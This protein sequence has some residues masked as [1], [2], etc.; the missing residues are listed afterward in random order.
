[1]VW[2]AAA[3]HPLCPPAAL[4]RVASGSEHQRAAAAANIACPQH[5]LRVL[6]ADRA[7]HVTAAAAGRCTAGPLLERAASD[8]AASDV[9]PGAMPVTVAALAGNP[10][11]A[12]RLLARLAAADIDE[13]AKER[14]AGNLRCPP[15][16]LHRFAA[17]PNLR[18]VAAATA[19]ANC[20]PE[21]LQQA[22]AANP[23]CPPD[24]R[25]KLALDP[26]PARTGA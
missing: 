7:R 26:D 24:L 2:W 10:H 23:N 15:E 12:P 13:I 16:L 1:M 14:L 20:P 9:A 19:N 3:T 18:V 11:R 5:L 17:D 6:L 25:E 22:A 4:Q 8:A 21:L